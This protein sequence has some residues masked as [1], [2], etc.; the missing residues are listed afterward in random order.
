MVTIAENAFKI[1]DKAD[2]QKELGEIKDITYVIAQGERKV[3]ISRKAGDNTN[4]WLTPASAYIPTTG[5]YND[6]AA[7]H[8]D[9]AS[10]WVDYD[11]LKI[12]S[13]TPIPKLSDYSKEIGK[14]T[15]ELQNN[16]AG[17]SCCPIP[18]NLVQERP[19]GYKKGNLLTSLLEVRLYQNQKILRTLIRRPAK[20]FR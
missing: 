7:E 17:N 10:L 15:P 4:T 18:T 13:G 12:S 3:F 1:F 19:S 16:L 11:A 6:T 2:A 9:Y 14:V 8:Y 5:D 20:V